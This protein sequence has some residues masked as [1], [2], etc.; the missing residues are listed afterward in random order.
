MSGRFL[1]LELPIKPAKRMRAQEGPQSA[2]TYT[3]EGETGQGDV[4]AELKN[5]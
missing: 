2:G 1:L 5:I 4:S 3:G